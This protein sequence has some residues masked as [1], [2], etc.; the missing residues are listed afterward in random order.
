[1]IKTINVNLN[2]KDGFSKSLLLINIIGVKYKIRITMASLIKEI[3]NECVSGVE[4]PQLSIHILNPKKAVIR[5]TSKLLES[6]LLSVFVCIRIL[7][8][9]LKKNPDRGCERL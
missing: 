9:K 6:E 7:N 8:Y 2:I 1:M 5:I 3:P 4:E